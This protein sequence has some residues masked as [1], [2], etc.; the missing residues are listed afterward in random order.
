M[1]VNSIDVTIFMTVLQFQVK[2]NSKKNMKLNVL[3][4]S[5]YLICKYV[6]RLSRK[7]LVLFVWRLNEKI[8]AR[9]CSGKRLSV[10]RNFRET[11]Y[12]S[13]FFVA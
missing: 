8:R 6:H 4:T 7:E 1:I 3:L 2:L 10:G 13:S 5:V 12:R 9:K 11:R